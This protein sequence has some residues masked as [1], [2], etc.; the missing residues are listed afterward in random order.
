MPPA[1]PIPDDLVDLQRALDAARAEKSAFVAEV[2]A[3]RRLEFGAPGQI[4]ERQTWPAGLDE[5]LDV[6]RA[7]EADA[8]RAVRRHPV[9]VAAL[10]G[11]YQQ[12]ERA[13]QEAAR[14][15]VEA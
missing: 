2:Q 14:R 12:T 9:M 3:A 5:K 4:V 8:A 15:P 1:L 10:A 7:L 6:L 13:L 11:T